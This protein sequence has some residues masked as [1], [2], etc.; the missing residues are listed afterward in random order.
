[1]NTFILKSLL[2]AAIAAALAF[3]VPAFGRGLG[4]GPR[5]RPSAGARHDAEQRSHEH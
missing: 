2:L 1:M 3:A 4:E 5:K